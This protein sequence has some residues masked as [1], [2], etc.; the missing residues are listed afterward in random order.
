MTSPPMRS[1]RAAGVSQAAS[2]AAVEDRQAGAAVGFVHQVGGEQDGHAVVL[3]DLA[4]V[5]PQSIR[6]PGSR[7]V[8][9]S[10]SS[11]TRGRLSSPLA[12]S[13]RRRMPPL[14]V[15]TMFAPAVGQADAGEE[16]VDAGCAARSRAGRRG[17]R[18][19]GGFP[20]R[21]AACR[22]WGTGRP[23]RSC[24]RTASRSAARSTPQH[25]DRPGGGGHERGEDAEEGGFAAAVG[26]EEAEDFAAVD[27]EGEVVEG[28]AVAVAV[29]ELVDLDDVPGGCGG[30]GG[31]V[32]HGCGRG[33]HNRLRMKHVRQRN[34]GFHLRRWG[35]NVPRTR[36]RW[37][38]I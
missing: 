1:L 33:C 14:K 31:N 29:G 30:V 36:R 25:R 3:L 21:S 15:P 6:A 16:F 20:R 12:S 18:G 2:R 24:W 37:L 32:R 4:E 27:V 19:G 28:D 8:L 9:G 38:A 13:T 5:S 35:R 10:S 26:A 11:R 17:G 23:R 34:E 22:G 7:P